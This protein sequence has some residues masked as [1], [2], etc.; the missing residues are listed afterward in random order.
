LQHEEEQEFPYQETP[1]VETQEEKI[2]KYA[3]MAVPTVAAVGLGGGGCNVISWVKEKGITGGKL[4][5]VNTDATHLR[6]VK[7]DKRILIGEKLTR[8]LGAGGYPDVGERALYESA[9]EVMHELSKSNIIFLVAGLGGGTG[10]GSIVGLADVMRKKFA[11]NPMAPL[12]VGVVTLP[13]EVETARLAAAKKGLNRLKDVCDSVVVIDNNRLVKVA[14]NLPFK[15]ALGVANTTVGKFVK[16]V[17]ETITTA[18][19]INMDYAD[20]KAI[21][22]GSGLASIGIGEGSGES[23][24]ETAVDKALNGRLLDIEDVTKA[25]GLLIHV[26]GGEDLTLGEVNRAAEIMK[27][28]L[29]PNVKIIW[30]A[31]VDPELKGAVSVMAVVTGVESAFLKKGEK[32]IGRLK[33]NL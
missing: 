21:M 12:L 27:R 33:F 19:L 1:F 4:I 25:Q 26:S 7:A 9:N 29:P 30:G 5:A 18:S 6:I 32:H 22:S 13:F 28:S 17:T 31:R 8:G 16:G 2:E 23:R 14:G 11:D 3:R 24:V 15:E 20:L 10:T